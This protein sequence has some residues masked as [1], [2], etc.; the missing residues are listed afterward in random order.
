M[1]QKTFWKFCCAFIAPT[2]VAWSEYIGLT[3]V[4]QYCTQIVWGHG[5]YILSEPFLVY[6]QIHRMSE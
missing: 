4:N 2:T 6:V 1:L 3:R 5:T